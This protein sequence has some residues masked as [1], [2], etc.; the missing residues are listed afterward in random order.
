MADEFTEP[1]ECYRCGLF[2]EHLG[3]FFGN[4]DGGAENARLRGA[5]CRRNEE[6]RQQ[7][8]IRL[9]NHCVAGTSLFTAASIARRTKAVN[10]TTHEA[11]PSP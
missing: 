5:R 7:Q 4:D 11:R 6:R 8:V 2:G 9:Y 3:L 1:F 10:V